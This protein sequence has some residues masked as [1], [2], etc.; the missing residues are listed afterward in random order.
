MVAFV[1]CKGT[2]RTHGHTPGSGVTTLGWVKIA[3]P[4][5][6]AGSLAAAV[7]VIAVFTVILAI[8][9]NGSDD[10]DAQL[11]PGVVTFPNDGLGN[12]AVEG[13]PLPMVDLGD[14]AGNEIET[15]SFLGRPLVINLWFADCP[16]CAKELPDF[17]AVP[18]QRISPP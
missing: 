16:P 9:D 15:A 17:A 7:L 5:L 8:S 2:F 13:E 18:L 6:L 14:A 1:F 10:V 3:R 12:T 4:R 11:T